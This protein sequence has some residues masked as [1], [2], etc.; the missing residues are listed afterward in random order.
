MEQDT[1]DTAD[2]GGAIMAAID[3]DRGSERFIIADIEAEEAWISV[4]R[5]DALSLN[6]WR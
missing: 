6:L 1:A 4:P 5:E 2:D 3:G